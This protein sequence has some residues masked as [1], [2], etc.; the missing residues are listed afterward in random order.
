MVTSM[1]SNMSTEQ[2]AFYVIKLV[3]RANAYVV[4]RHGSDVKDG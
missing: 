4:W 1:L 3:D 2:L